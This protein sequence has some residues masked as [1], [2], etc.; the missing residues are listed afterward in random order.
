MSTI[1][2]NSS[3]VLSIAVNQ[4]SD[5]S[6]AAGTSSAL[7]IAGPLPI[8]G[9]LPITATNS[10]AVAATAPSVVSPAA[11]AS[12]S[13]VG[14][15]HVTVNTTVVSGQPST[16]RCSNGRHHH[17]SPSPCDNIRY[18]F[19]GA[20]AF[21]PTP[22]PVTPRNETLP[23][24]APA[25]TATTPP[26]G[27]PTALESLQ[28]TV[29]TLTTTM[30]QMMDKLKE[31]ITGVATNKAAASTANQS[32]ASPSS[33]SPTGSTLPRGMKFEWRAHS[34]K[35]GKLVVLIPKSMNG[36][37][38]VK[39]LSPDR[40]QVLG[41]GRKDGLTADKQA[42]IRF[43][44]TGESYPAGSIVQFTDSSGKVWEVAV[45]RTSGRYQY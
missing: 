36:C 34:G 21:Q 42:Q 29:K 8:I 15:P 27:Q 30:M 5:F 24:V 9:T 28:D 33:T 17:H 13:G 18:A 39:I 26:A 35:D 41:S 10:T 11:A 12:S 23:V 40:T 3:Q 1:Q 25:T 14:V 32:S 37:T 45:P 22:P 6:P 43:D 2:V 19:L 31:I 20:V 7:P 4:Q 38:D 16:G 44:Q